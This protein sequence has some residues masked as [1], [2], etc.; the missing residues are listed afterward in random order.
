VVSRLPKR[1]DSSEPLNVLVDGTKLKT[2]G[3]GWLCC[4]KVGHRGVWAQYPPQP[5]LLFKRYGH[6][7]GIRAPAFGSAWQLQWRPRL[8]RCAIEEHR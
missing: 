3:E 8:D 5:S 4:M 6:S 1:I 2:Y 7:S